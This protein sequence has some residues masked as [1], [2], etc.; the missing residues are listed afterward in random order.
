MRHYMNPQG[1]WVGTQAE[2]KKIGATMVD[3]P[4]DK[5]N[6]LQWLNN[7][8]GAIDT[9]AEEVIRE[10]SE[11]PKY[12]HNWTTI[13]E[14]AEK[15]PLKDLGVALSVLMNRLDEVADKQRGEL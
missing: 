13:K 15:A 3:V 4:T 1:Q 8:T 12:K 7:W 2:A 5:P 11:A 6:L 14:C 10:K 9:A